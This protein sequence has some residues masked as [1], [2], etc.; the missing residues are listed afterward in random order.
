[1]T[2][3][4]FLVLFTIGFVIIALGYP[5]PLTLLVGGAALLASYA[6]IVREL[7]SRGPSSGVKGPG[8]A[9]DLP[10]LYAG[11]DPIVSVPVRKSIGEELKERILAD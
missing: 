7:A 1:M 5:G 10:P 9:G 6:G 11:K 4:S 2:A 3:T 8:Q